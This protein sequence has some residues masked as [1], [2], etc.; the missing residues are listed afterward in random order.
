ME[1]QGLK[2]SQPGSKLFQVCTSPTFQETRHY[3]G[4]GRCGYQDANLQTHQPGWGRQEWGITSPEQPP[5]ALHI[6][7]DGKLQ[8]FQSKLSYCTSNMPPPRIKNKCSQWLSASSRHCWKAAP[9]SVS[10]H[11]KAGLKLHQQCVPFLRGA[12]ISGHR[13]LCPP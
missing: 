8:L 2:P 12:D 9:S 6:C 10:S 7:Q 4:P 5:A 11:P 13:L 1:R 3:F